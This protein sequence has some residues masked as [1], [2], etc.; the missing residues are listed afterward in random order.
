MPF[1]FDE[2][3][4]KDKATIS[5]DPS[6]A[7]EGFLTPDAEENNEVSSINA[8]LAGIASGLIKIPQ[9]VVSLGAELMDYGLGTD[10][11]R[12][13]ENFFDK[14]NPFEEVAQEKAAGKILEAIVSVGMP[15]GAGAKIAT[16]LA[17][18]A[19]NAKKAGR[20]V[21]LKS[22]NLK[23][24][25]KK[26]A[27]LNQL[28]GKQKFAAV[29]I[30]GSAGETLVGDVENIG[31]LGDVFEAGPTELDREVQ[32]DSSADAQRKLLNRLRFGAEGLLTTPLYYGAGKIIKGL[33]T[34]GKEFAYSNSKIERVL[35]KAAGLF[36][37]RA[38]KPEEVFLS[39]NKEAGRK[40]ADV[41]FSMEQVKRIDKEVDKMFPEVRSFFNRSSDGERK[42]FMKTLNDT[43]F[44]GDLKKPIPT[45]VVDSLM[46]VM[47][48]KD[49]N[50]RSMKNIFTAIGNVRNKF[51]ELLDITEQGP[52]GLAGGQ[53]QVL[54]GL[55]ADKTKQYLG[56]TYR[57]FQDQ[58]FGFYSA[59][60]PTQQ[61]VDKVKEIFKRYAAKNGNPI[62]DLEA[63]NLVNN[64]LEQAKQ[65][66]KKTSLP[67]FTYDNLT[68]GATTP[69]VTK[70]FA[71][72]LQKNLPG[73][74]KQL[75][76]IGQGSKAFRELFGNIEDA[77]Y[78]IYEGIGRL[79]TIARKNQL[80]DEILDTD[81]ALKAAVTK[82]TPAGARGFFFADKFEA[83][84][85][86]PN[87]PIVKIDDYVQDY[88]KDGVLVNRLK[89]MYTT[90]D[91]AEAFQNGNWV[92][93]YLR[94][95][96]GPTFVKGASWLYRNLLLTPKAGAQYAKTVLSIPTHFRNFLSSGAFAL[97]NGNIP[98]Q[99]P[100]MIARAVKRAQETVQ[101][102]LRDPK[103]MDRYRRYLELGVANT[104]VR[105]GD[106]KNM[107]RDVKF[108]E[109]GNL[110]TDSVLKP[111]INS[112]GKIGQAGKRAVKKT[113]QTMQDAY[114]AED[115]FW[116]IMSFEM[117]IEKL[118]NA[119]AKSGIKKTMKQL[120]EESADIIRNTIPNYSYVG[121]FVKGLRALPFGNFIS[122]PVEVYR[123][124]FGIVNRA[125]KEI[126]DPKTGKINP[127]TSTNPL[128]G[129]GMKRL[130]GAIT[131]FGALPYGIVQGTRS[132]SGVSDKEAEAA[133]DFIAPW[134]KNSQNIF[135]KDPETGELYHSDWSQNNVYDTLTR[136]F[137]T[138]L[139]N[140]QEG[141]ESEEILM[142][143]FTKG[144]AEAIGEISDPFI[145]PSI[146][147]EA[148]MD[149]YSRGG[150]T[151]DGVEIYTAN[152]PAPERFTRAVNHII[153]TQLPGG[154]NQI[155]NLINSVTGKKDKNGDVLEIP[156][157]LAG[158]MGFKLTK[159]DPKKA[160]GFY[161]PKYQEGERNSRKEFT[162]GPEGVL[163]PMKT[164]QDV[165]ERYFVAN[166]A[167]FD[168][169]NAMKKHMKNASTL[170][171]SDK[172]I[173]IIFDK[174]GM[175]KDYGYLKKDLFDPFFPSKGIQERFIE[176]AKEKNE[177]NPFKEALPVIKKMYKA[178]N[179]QKLGEDF[180]FKLED[181]LPQPAPGSEQQ[182]FLPPQPSPNQQVISPPMPQ[183]SQLNQGL[184]PAESALLS[185]EEQQMRL[186]QR[187]LA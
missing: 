86:L 170:K 118:G 18:K 52:I 136:P 38:D 132:I 163:K 85:N 22:A 30:G 95:E 87:N 126:A 5:A 14:I 108:G 149:I 164:S 63:E 174:R 119:Y 9:G 4:K 168:V 32:A 71:R 165:I 101:L 169:H 103:S 12:D 79:S 161:L 36:R 25:T 127:F 92:S 151:K 152:T 154:T 129:I 56:A 58:D 40:M 21:N 117:E 17:T 80:F 41:N 134:S 31:T 138:L 10:T 171:I 23:K 44:A 104:N 112:L 130:V 135:I 15:A 147:T 125:L 93:E 50:E 84:R 57:I 167:L 37:A 6:I 185:N 153:K 82:D 78:S 69:E 187:G 39:L 131:A 74:E 144:I 109:D 2:K 141:I 106:L 20:Y 75:Q 64:V 59:Y 55:M 145:S 96:K 60:K 100:A 73:G 47:K 51:N 46:K 140:V 148:I 26:A 113:A 98:F 111:M 62:T 1:G 99:N 72:T 166:K 183:V 97:A 110:V 19:L 35:N 182:G 24:G 123:T 184:T 70:T 7:G 176:I 54:R 114:V 116:K 45:K 3:P 102:G 180:K 76:V 13:V 8:G 28:T 121:D 177:P 65:Y 122:W 173:A 172:D 94:G 88:F 48:D 155:G 67:S 66:G 139:R 128:K 160:L 16:K 186:K 162:G 91:I 77:R 159:V 178:F 175:K 11:A 81:E 53:A 142:K 83:R 137:Q 158:V 143:G 42:E 49:L 181:F 150:V 29:V 124:G 115:D 90:K 27:E 33:A 105:I 34:R 133:T 68:L 157:S 89:G 120:E 146:F 107:M 43:M 61:S 179:S 156:K